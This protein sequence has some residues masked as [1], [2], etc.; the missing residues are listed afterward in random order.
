[1]KKI[2]ILTSFCLSNLL[3]AALPH[4]PILTGELAVKIANEAMKQCKNDG[5]N[6]TTTVV[7]NKGVIL[8]VARNEESGPHTVQASF[9]KAFTAASM[10][11]STSKIA[12]NIADG[13]SPQGLINLNDNFVFLGGGL[14]IKFDDIVV[15]GVGVG[16]APGGHLD[17]KCAQAG[18]DSIK[19]FLQK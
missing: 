15:G 1:M 2:L 17:D 13:K 3:F 14:P 12:K 19:M 4:S 10:K 8:A 5:Y 7:D 11:N 6:V 18:I 9:R 16:G